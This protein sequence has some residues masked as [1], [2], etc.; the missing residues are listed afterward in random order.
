MAK[1]KRAPRLQP[2]VPLP[3]IRMFGLGLV[4]VLVVIW[5]LA[6]PKRAW[7]LRV[8]PAAAPASSPNGEIEVELEDGG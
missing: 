7:P 3:V 2:S 1:P 6:R 4:S 5:A 8:V